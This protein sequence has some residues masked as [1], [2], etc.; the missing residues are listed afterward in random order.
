MRPLFVG[1]H[2]AIDF[3]NTL[4]APNGDPIETIPDGRAWLDWLVEARLLDAAQATRLARRFGDKAFDAAAAEAREVREWARAWLVR[5]RARPGRDYGAE[6]E[7]L[8]GLL[9]R[10][11]VTRQVV[12]R[13]DR[14]GGPALDL[15]DTMQFDSADALIAAVAAELAALVAKEQPALVKECASSV[16]TLWFLDRSRAHTRM[17]CSPTSCGNREKVAAYRARQ[18]A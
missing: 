12:P 11:R 9:A 13:K 6:L 15:I 18:R 1:N 10:A 2:P 17:F 14:N 7:K 3:L 4:L 5:W 8:N 16:C